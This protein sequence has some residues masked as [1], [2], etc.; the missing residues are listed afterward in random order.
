MPLDPRAKAFL[1]SLAKLGGLSDP[2]TAGIEKQRKWMEVFS[3]GQAGKAQAV[4][5]VE[6]RRIPGPDGQ[7]PVRVYSPEGREPLPVL[8]YFHG[9]A[10]T[11]GSLESEDAVCRRLANGA[12]CVVVSVDYRLAPEHK[13][14]A[15]AEDCY[16]ATKWVA[17]HAA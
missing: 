13:F 8:V 16:A 11:M 17:D 4:S 14:P 3:R 10:F 7:I 15:G 5:L 9:G 2:R 12:G 1:D 6:D